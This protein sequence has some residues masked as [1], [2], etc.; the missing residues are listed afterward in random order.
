MIEPRPRYVGD[1]LMSDCEDAHDL[2]PVREYKLP[3]EWFHLASSNEDQRKGI[4]N[5]H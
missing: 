4:N 2:I 5:G 3:E 1:L